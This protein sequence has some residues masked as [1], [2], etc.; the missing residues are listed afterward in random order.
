MKIFK[1]YLLLGLLATAFIFS[2]CEDDD[3]PP[4]ENPEEEINRVIVNFT[5]VDDNN[6]P[7]GGTVVTAVWFDADFEGPNPPTQEEITLSANTA[8][9]LTWGIELELNGETED[10]LGDDISKEQDQHQFFFEFTADIFSSP[11]GNGNIDMREA[12][13]VNYLDQ[14]VNGLPVGLETRWVT[15]AATTGTFTTVLKH[16]PPNGSTAVKTATSNTTSG[17]TDIDIDWTLNIN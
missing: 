10:I 5:P 9:L 11:M 12:G 17:G 6:N 3:V 1:N 4:E 15:G 2:G 14:D 13:A 7:T 8:Y 16:Q